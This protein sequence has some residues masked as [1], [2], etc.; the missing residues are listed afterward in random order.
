M[1]LLKAMALQVSFPR[2]VTTLQVL[3]R[4]SVPDFGKSVQKDAR[5]LSESSQAVEIFWDRATLRQVSP[6]LRL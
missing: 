3:T 5:W 2:T 4:H 6:D 1:L